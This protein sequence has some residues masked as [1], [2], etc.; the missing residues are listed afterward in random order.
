[1]EKKNYF[2]GKAEIKKKIKIKTRKI[3]IQRDGSN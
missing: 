2:F 1:M 3:K